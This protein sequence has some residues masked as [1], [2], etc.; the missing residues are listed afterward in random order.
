VRTLVLKQG[1]HFDLLFGATA[2]GLEGAYNERLNAVAQKVGKGRWH[3][4]MFRHE[5]GYTMLRAGCSIKYIQQF[6]NHKKIRT[7]EIYT[8]VDVQDVRKVLDT[9]HPLG[10]P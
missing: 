3:S 6:L 5:F 1:S 9:Y 4:H 2:I 10:Q 8:K 7:T